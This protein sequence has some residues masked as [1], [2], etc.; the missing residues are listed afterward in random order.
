MLVVTSM[1]PAAASVYDDGIRDYQAG[2]FKQ[3]MMKLTRASGAQPTNALVHYYL[4]NALVKCGEHE[5]AAEEYRVSFM[6]DPYG[7]VSG[8]CRAALRGYKRAVPSGDD[9]KAFR[10]TVNG[11]TALASAPPAPGAKGQVLHPPRL[12]A[13]ASADPIMRQSLSLIRRQVDFEKRK[14]NSI[15]E[16]RAKSEIKLAE[17]DARE[18]DYWA[19]QQIDRLW[20]PHQAPMDPRL[21]DTKQLQASEDRIRANAKEEQSRILREAQQ[22]ADRYRK[23]AEMRKTALDEVADNLERQMCEN[24]SASTVRLLSEGTD[25]YVRRYASTG[26]NRGIPDA[27]P[28]VARI[29][30]SPVVDDSTDVDAH[31]DDHTRSTNVRSRSVSGKVLN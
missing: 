15:G 21:L 19:K 4:A 12:G 28:A 27:H 8:Y 9:I 31:A 25:L 17:R 22:R 14:N 29:V 1:L 18:I 6:L 26:N 13:S 16:S 3:A 23:V 20:S 5:Q 10:D 2:R 7:T 24:S 30:S 11:V